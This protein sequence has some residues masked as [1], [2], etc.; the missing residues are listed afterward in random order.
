M[1]M[2]DM[3]RENFRK[4]T[5]SIGSIEIGLWLDRCLTLWYRAGDDGTDR[6]CSIESCSIVEL[7]LE[8]PVIV[9]FCRLLFFGIDDWSTI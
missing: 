2:Q 5:F 3:E 6:V 4:H 9:I 8:I 1:K 7:L